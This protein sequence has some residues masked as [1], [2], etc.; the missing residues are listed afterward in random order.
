MKAGGKDHLHR[1]VCDRI[2]CVCVRLL[3]RD[4]MGW[5]GHSLARFFGSIVSL[6]DGFLWHRGCMVNQVGHIQELLT[7]KASKS[8]KTEGTRNGHFIYIYIEWILGEFIIL[9]SLF[10]ILQAQD[11]SSDVR[12][13][14]VTHWVMGRCNRLLTYRRADSR[15]RTIQWHSMTTCCETLIFGFEAARLARLHVRVNRVRPC[16]K[17]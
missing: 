5:C 9:Y 4:V 7:L 15:W 8:R 3:L 16:S 1:L 10:S 2:V 13:R 11:G 6:S 14:F 12:Y 17:S